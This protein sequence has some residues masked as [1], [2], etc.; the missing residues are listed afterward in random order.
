[1]AYTIISQNN[2][3][4]TLSDENGNVITVPARVTLATSTDYTITKVNNNSVD[5]VDGNGKVIRGVPACVVLAGGGDS[6]NLGYYATQAALEEA[7][8]T[9]EAGDY[10]IVGS[11]DTVWVWDEDTSAWKDS[12]QKGQVTSVNNQTGDVTLTASDVGALPDN[13]HIPADPVQADW[14]EA[15]STALDY[16]KNKP[17]IPSAQVNSDWN[18]NSG[19]AEILNKPT[20]PDAIQYSTMPTASA[21]N[22]GDIVQF[23]GTTDAN[24]TNGYFYQCVSDG[25]EPATYSWTQT[26]VQPAPSGLP[27]Q[28]GQSGKFLTTDGTDAGW[29][30]TISGYLTENVVREGAIQYY[31]RAY[32]NNTEVATISCFYNEQAGRIAFKGQDNKWCR[33]DFTASNTSISVRPQQDN[34]YLLGDGTHRWT[35]VYTTKLNNG[36]DISIPA[37]AGTMAVIGVNTTATL[38]VADWSSNTQ[39]VT[40]SGVKAD[41]VVFVSPAPASASDYASAGILCT[42]QAADSLT[43]TCTQTPSNAITVNVICL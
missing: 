21:D 13:T 10:A 8:P 23:T 38:A 31:L 32:Y 4:T 3:T 39:T 33:I 20:I 36:G 17:T 25:Q 1:M 42:A 5:L 27:D 35:T 11:T 26:N 18:A 9:A 29:G 19:V 40:V 24:Y 28:T 37:T 7:H 41:S 2:T 34:T 22:L 12:D 15:D 30:T 6:H 14:D 16:I 43:F